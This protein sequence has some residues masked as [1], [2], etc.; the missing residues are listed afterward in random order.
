M[1]IGLSLTANCWLFTGFEYWQILP[2]HDPG[3]LVKYMENESTGEFCPILMVCCVN[4]SYPTTEQSRTEKQRSVRSHMG[5]KYT[6]IAFPNV[7]VGKRKYQ[8]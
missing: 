1:V 7:L 2:S 5:Q 4:N 8:R 3:N 6:K